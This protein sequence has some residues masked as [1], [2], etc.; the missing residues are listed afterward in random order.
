VVINIGPHTYNLKFLDVAET[1]LTTHTNYG[2]TNKYTHE[3]TVSSGIPTST[4][5]VTLLHELLHA[6]HD[7]YVPDGVLSDEIEEVIVDKY[8][9]GLTDLFQRNVEVL[10]QIFDWAIEQYEPNNITSE[11]VDDIEEG[12]DNEN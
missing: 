1:E 2:L 9:M 11:V 10:D 8:A 3:I 4:M 12:E 6:I 7:I 5:L